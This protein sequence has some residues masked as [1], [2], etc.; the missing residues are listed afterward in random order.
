[1]A[2][3]DSELGL[4]FLGGFATRKDDSGALILSAQAVGESGRLG[5]HR[6][7]KLIVNSVPSISLLSP[8]DVSYPTDGQIFR[9]LGTSLNGFARAYPIEVMSNHEIANDQFGDAHVA[10]AY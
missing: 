8:R 2:N 9:V 6:F 5:C 1:M 7:G 4:V 3:L 10:V